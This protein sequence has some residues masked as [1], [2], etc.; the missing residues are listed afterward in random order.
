MADLVVHIDDQIVTVT[1]A[2]ETPGRPTTD[3]DQVTWQLPVGSSV[4][5]DEHLAVGDPPGPAALTNALGIVADHLD[6]LIVM[7]DGVLRADGVTVRG[8]HA[9]VLARVE[10][11]LDDLPFPCT[12]TR[13]DTDEMFRAVATER[14]VDRLANPG[15]PAAHVDTVVATCCIVLAVLRRLDHA[16]YVVDR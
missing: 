14:R 1:L 5:H 3:S 10:R 2:D 16:A 13:A 4:L 11:G 12:V 9:L 15:L 8:E 6:N 7:N